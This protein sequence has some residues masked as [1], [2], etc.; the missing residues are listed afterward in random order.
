MNGV[1]LLSADI[2]LFIVQLIMITLLSRTLGTILKFI[3]QPR[4]IAEV[5]AGILLGPTA[6]GR[7]PGFTATIFP[8]SRLNILS[9]VANIGLILFL[10]MVGMEL[11][12]SLLRKD[13]KKSMAISVAGMAVPFGFGAAV[14][15]FLYQAF[16]VRLEEAPPFSSVVLFLGV[17]MS[18]TAFP[19]LARILTETRLISAPVGITAIS[20]AAVDDAAAWCLLALVIAIVGSHDPLNTLYIFLMLIGFI[21]FMFLGAFLVR[22][23]Y[24]VPE[25]ITQELVVYSLLICFAAAWVTDLIGVH[26]IFGAFITGAVLPRDNHFTVQLIEKIEDLTTFIFLPLYFAYSGLRTD[27]GLLDSGLAWGAVFLVIF[28]A[29]AGKI[30]GVGGTCKALGMGWRDTITVAFLM[31]TKG[32]VE[33]IVLNI[34]LDAAIIDTTVFTIMV[35]MALVTTFITS[36]V[37]NFVYPPKLRREVLKLERTMSSRGLPQTKSIHLPDIGILK[38]MLCIPHRD[39][40]PHAV[41]LLS[42][43]VESQKSVS[44]FICAKLTK[45]TDRESSVFKI[46]QKSILKDSHQP[47]MVHPFLLVST[48]PFQDHI[49]QK[50]LQRVELT[51]EEILGTLEEFPREIIE[52]L[53]DNEVDILFYPFDVRNDLAE[54]QSLSVLLQGSPCAVSLYI[55]ANTSTVLGSGHG[56]IFVPFLGGTNDHEAVRMAVSLSRQTPVVIGRFNLYSPDTT[57]VELPGGDDNEL[58]NEVQKLIEEGTPN[59]S[60]SNFNCSDAALLSTIEEELEKNYSLVV[61]GRNSVAVVGN[62]GDSKFWIESSI[63]FGSLG[64]HLMSKKFWTNMLIVNRSKRNPLFFTELRISSESSSL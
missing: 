32:L 26:S 41:N 27:L 60:I 57:T 51:H 22:K 62:N 56:K 29:C 38:G 31:N 6:M 16:L 33:L 52:V 2:S 8:A 42:L 5:I 64:A 24:K 14:S 19:V 49:D 17:A 63:V 21:S 53:H 54:I 9:I 61:L 40:L 28:T 13:W 58:L 25:K 12:L 11:D 46:T 47:L 4:V 30:L 45:I 18:I 10:F 36:P 1:P 39:S 50:L 34:G 7:I 59:L 15:V 43:L 23:F 44:S 37:V 35:V 55:P 3:K 20:A 48:H